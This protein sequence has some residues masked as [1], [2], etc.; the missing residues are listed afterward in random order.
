[1]NAADADL[2]L[3]TRRPLPSPR[4]R[5]VCC[6]YAGG[7]A[8]IFHKWTD[9]LPDDVEVRAAQLPARQD[10]FSERPLTR[11]APIVDHLIEALVALP[12][13]PVALYGHSLGGLVAF[14]LARRLER[15]GARPS[16][17]VIGAT[18]APG[19]DSDA[20]P[21]HLMGRE[22]FLEAMHQRYGTPWS[23]LRND[24]LMSLALPSLRAD[25]E[26]FEHYQ[27]Q[28][29]PSLVAPITILRGL[30]DNRMSADDAAAW[31]EFTCAPLTVA[32]IDAG[33]FFVDSHGDWVT[34]QVQDAL[35][36]G[37]LNRETN[38]LG[39]RAGC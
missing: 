26:A 6:P 27:C 20:P 9:K 37:S 19:R 25:M 17:L 11:I 39:E 35:A 8:T 21:L 4:I 28:P 3:R 15:R 12:P 34:G 22:G 18:R 31:S 1:M 29:G 30:E 24:E 13:A 33:H 32:E 2:W 5:L 36:R 7:G 16:A 23:V 10:R 14:E 38:V